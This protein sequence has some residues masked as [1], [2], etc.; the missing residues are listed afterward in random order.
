L[1]NAEVKAL[2]NV[3]YTLLTLTSARAVTGSSTASARSRAPKDRGVKR[4]AP[5]CCKEQHESG[6]QRP[7]D[8]GGL[9]HKTRAE[10]AGL[11]EPDEIARLREEP[12]DDVADDKNRDDT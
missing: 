4:Q 3:L 10:L 5:S 6:K 2:K 12:R 7:D 9:V 1:V 8:K 11:R